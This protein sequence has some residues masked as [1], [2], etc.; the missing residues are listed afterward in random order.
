MIKLLVVASDIFGVS[1]RDMMAALVAGERD[2]KVL[3]QM[4]RGR[5]RTKTAR[6]EEAFTGRFTDHHAFLLRT[7]LA[8]IDGITADMDIVQDRIDEQIAPFAAAVT[9][10][11]EIP[12]VGVT[13]AQAIIAE[14]GSR[15]ALLRSGPLRT[16]RAPHRR[17]RLKQAARALRVAVLVSCVCGLG[18][19]GGRRCVSSGCGSC[20][21]HR[22][23]R[24]C[25]RGGRRRSPC[26]PRSATSVPIPE[27][28]GAAG[29]G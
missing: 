29:R 4:A 28:T 10:L 8:R 11:D 27:G 1:G 15:S 3:A 9:Q 22:A 2:P 26:G 24:G 12:G 5:M 18:A 21:A 6:L 14:S 13:T 20:P 19:R 25:G 16:V 7:M 17:T 23:R